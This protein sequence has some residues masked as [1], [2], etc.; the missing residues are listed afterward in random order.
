MLCRTKLNIAGLSKRLL[1]CLLALVC[2]VQVLAASGE[3]KSLVVVSIKPLRLIAQE[4]AGEQFKLITLIPEVGSH[5]DYP[6]KPS[7][8]QWLQQAKLVIWVG[9]S[10]ESFLAKPLAGLPSARS[11]QMGQLAG[12]HWPGAGEN[13]DADPH[14][15]LDINNVK[16][17]ARAIAQ[18]FVDLDPSHKAEFLARERLLEERLTQLDVRL[19]EQLRGIESAPFVVYHDGL[20]HWAAHYR[21]S[22]YGYITLTPEQKPGAKHLVMLRKKYANSK[23]CLFMEPNLES[24]SAEGLAKDLG[25][26]LGILDIMGVSGVSR[27]DELLA[28]LG[29]VFTDC[30]KR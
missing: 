2:S 22:G 24:D 16:L 6:L 23:G 25:L 11:L 10:L 5:H 13:G 9:P 15:W 8:H 3:T 21:L 7:D 28:Q 12:L 4:L 18:R 30:L 29:A 14:F 20:G 26:K 27:I 1:G 17:A 19:S